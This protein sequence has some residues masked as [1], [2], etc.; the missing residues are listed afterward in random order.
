MQLRFLHAR[1]CVCAVLAIA[2]MMAA[3][4]SAQPTA[5]PVLFRIVLPRP[6]VCIADRSLEVEAELRNTS[7]RHLA[8]SPAGL[9]SQVSFT[10][11]ASSLEDGFRS[12]NSSNDPLPGWRGGR[13]VTL[14]PGASYRQVLKLDLA[15]DFFSP[16]VYRIQI[17]YSG[18]YGAV[19]KDGLFLGA[20]DSNEALFEVDDCQPEKN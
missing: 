6:V 5:Q 14:A 7:D 12:K 16:G 8:L 2:V 4:A 10:N 9:L 1:C 15:P 11:R 17:S 13:V 20:V 19:E 18:R 3:K